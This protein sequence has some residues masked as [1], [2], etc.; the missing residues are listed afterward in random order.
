MRKDREVMKKRRQSKETCQE[1]RNKRTDQEQIKRLD[2]MRMPA[3]KERIRLEKRI[4]K[5]SK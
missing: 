5:G 2:D 1:A 3:L 4:A